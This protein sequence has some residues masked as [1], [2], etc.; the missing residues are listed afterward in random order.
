MLGARGRG[1]V[2]VLRG[3]AAGAEAHANVKAHGGVAERA[4]LWELGGQRG[5]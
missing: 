4:A 3:A 1:R 2:G 5:D